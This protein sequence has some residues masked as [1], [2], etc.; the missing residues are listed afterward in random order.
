MHTVDLL[1]TR[2]Q[3]GD[4]TGKPR[5]ANLYGMAFNAW[6]IRILQK[7]CSDTTHCSRNSREGWSERF[8]ERNGSFA[9]SVRRILQ[10]THYR[11]FIILMLRRNVP[12]VGLYMTS[13]TQLR[14]AMATSPYFRKD[15]LAQGNHSSVL[16]K[17][18][19]QGNLLSGATARVA[20]GFLLNP[21]SVLKARF[22]VG[23]WLSQICPQ[24]TRLLRRAIYM[25][26]RVWQARLL[27][28]SV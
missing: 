19:V 24:L 9:D 15:S 17:L 21:F 25:P 3:Q 6:I 7:Y 20:I 12:G 23:V 11:R 2:V 4:G 14:I 22:E 28:L 13:L 26:T 10:I 18:T 16:P 1:K 8:M 27:L 5:S